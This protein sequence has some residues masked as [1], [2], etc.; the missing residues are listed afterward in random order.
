MNQFFT[1][2]Q[3]ALQAEFGTEALA[4]R[5]EAGIVRDSLAGEQIR[6]VESVDM[7]FLASVDEQDRPT[8]SYK[9][10]APGFV[11][12]IGSQTL[13]F[14][15]Y[16]GNG[17]FHSMG[18]IQSC[19]SI[20]LLFIN[21]ERPQR[22]RVQGEAR[23]LRDGPILSGYPGA[24]LAVEVRVTDVWVNCPRYLHTMQKV[25]SSS[26]VPDKDGNSRIALW[27]RIDGMQ[28]VLN[29]QDRDAAQAA[30]LITEAEYAAMIGAG[31]V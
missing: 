20:G 26:Y 21:F 1:K 31:E 18:N 22:L 27:K 15:S 30:G 13:A 14:P 24:A 16:D 12:V 10:G 11:R 6:F 28:D 4:E 8:V 2:S 25:D 3:Q 7:F 19:S 5:L 29:A 9:G 23:L 17:M